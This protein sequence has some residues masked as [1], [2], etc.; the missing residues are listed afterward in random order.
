MLPATFETPRLLARLPVP[1]DAQLIFAA[2]ASKPEVSRYM[3][4]RPHADVA[5]TESFIS[6]C[7]AAAKAGVRMPYVLSE[8]HSP[9]VLIGMLEARPLACKVDLGYVLSP[10]VWGRG[11][12]PEAISGLTAL[13]L[14]ESEVFRVQ[15]FCDVENVP[16]QRALE[17]SGFL[18][19]GRHERFFVH[20]NLSSEPRSCYM[21]AKCR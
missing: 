15:A 5:T 12:M 9:N 8:R 10:S 2:Y 20:P 6:E 19:E 1:A 4:W 13:A 16:S 11:Y 21:Y 7:I 14:G 3:V 17:K 18:R